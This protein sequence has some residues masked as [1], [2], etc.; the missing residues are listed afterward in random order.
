M[1]DKLREIAMLLTLDANGNNAAGPD[2]DPANI[3]QFGY[4]PIWWNDDIR[5]GVTSPFGAGSFLP[6]RQG[7]R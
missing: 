7:K 5:S 6:S 4:S 1:A 3:V 2:F